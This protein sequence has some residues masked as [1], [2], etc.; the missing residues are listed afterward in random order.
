[1]KV[2]R[3]QQMERIENAAE[4]PRVCGVPILPLAANSFGDGP[5][6]ILSVADFK[7]IVAES[8]EYFRLNIMMKNLNRKDLQTPSDSV[9][10]YLTLWIREL[11]VLASA[12]AE[13]K[14]ITFK[15][16]FEQ[17]FTDLAK[18]E[19]PKAF[20]FDT[21]ASS[22]KERAKFEKYLMQLRV[23]TARRVSEKILTDSEGTVSVS[24][25]WAQYANVPT[26]VVI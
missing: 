6:Q 23:E 21:P 11:L 24:K 8:I 26:P 7:D 25:W 20:S 3:S 22:E 17:R 13:K 5:C 19:T 9:L 4:L 12:S 1:M 10:I 2:Y 16:E 18:S 15:S 14:G